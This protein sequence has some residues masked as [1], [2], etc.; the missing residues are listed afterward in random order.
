M[1]GFQRNI[2][3]LGFSLLACFMLSATH[4]S[5]YDVLSIVQS[6]HAGGETT[7]GACQSDDEGNGCLC[8]CHISAESPQDDF[9]SYSLPLITY[10]TNLTPTNYNSITL[11]TFERPPE[12]L[13]A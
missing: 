2:A 6:D 7:T 8:I 4:D 10:L 5:V 9:S 12:H 3:L 13:Q 11:D 1:K